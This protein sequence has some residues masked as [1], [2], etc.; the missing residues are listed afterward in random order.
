MYRSKFLK[1]HIKEGRILD[2]GNLG[3]DGEI[4][5]EIQ[6]EFP[7]SLVIGMDN[8]EEL[9]KKTNFSNQIIGDITKTLPFENDYFD[10][11]YLGEII[12]HVWEPQKLL[13]EVYRVLKK[14][15]VVIID[16]PHVYSL[17]RMIRFFVKGQDFLGEPSHKIFFTPVILKN[18]LEKC[19]FDIVEITT[20]SKFSFRNK[21]LILPAIPPFKWLGSHLCVAAKKS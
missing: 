11:V 5:R 1:K 2:V 19:Y 12:E 15:G 20:D 10:T 18:L 13:Q 16:T 4:H 14:G 7:K 8:N 9:A 17:I 3:Y 6:A 21:E